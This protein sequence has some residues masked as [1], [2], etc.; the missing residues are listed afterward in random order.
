MVQTTSASS[1]V[2]AAVSAA[3]TRFIGVPDIA[4]SLAYY[5]R[6]GLPRRPL[7]RAG[8]GVRTRALRSRPSLRS[9]RL[10]HQDADHGLVRLMQWERPRNDGLGLNPTCAASGVAG[11]CD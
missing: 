7:R 3:S 11:V 9:L 1:S 4:A 10:Y 6:F 2:R 5:E 8:R